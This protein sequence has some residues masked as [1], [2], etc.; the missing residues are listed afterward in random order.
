MKKQ[1]R[2]LIGVV[3]A[4]ICLVAPAAAETP[5]AIVEDVQGTV[6]GAEFMDY[7]APGKVIKLEPEAKLVLSYLKSCLHETIT[8]GI[9]LVGAE[10]SSV[11]FG[12]VQRVKVPCDMGA[13][14][15]SD[16]EANQSAATTF[17][18]AD[19]SG[20]AK[21]LP[22]LYGVSPLIE[23][24]IGGALMIERVDDESGEQYSVPLNVGQ[25]VRGKF[26]DFAMVGKALTPGATYLAI[27]GSR[28][29]V[30]VVDSSATSPAPIISRLLR[31]E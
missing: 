16:E 23:A 15:L 28:R 6:V 27:L 19:H 17:R 7:V 4:V 24:K 5:V 20:P 25:M 8:G 10:E 11:Q 12:E 30:F 1:M 18:K 3:V 22:T 21:K 26:Y 13:I 14:Q 2:N 31:L 29:F 9:V